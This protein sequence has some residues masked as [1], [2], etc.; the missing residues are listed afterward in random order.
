MSATSDPV[1]PPFSPPNSPAH[2]E[3]PRPGK[4]PPRRDAAPKPR[5]GP[6]LWWWGLAWKL[7]VAAV[8]LSGIGAGVKWWLF[9]DGGLGSEITATV[10]R[11]DLPVVVT[12]RGELDSSKTEDIRC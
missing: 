1:I 9:P 11:G 7:L 5:P 12:E 4:P 10:T 3:P 8:A 6:S 2:P